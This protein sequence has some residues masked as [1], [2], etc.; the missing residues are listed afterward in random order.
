MQEM[1]AKASWDVA[2]FRMD[3]ASKKLTSMPF[4]SDCPQLSQ[5]P[6]LTPNDL[7]RAGDEGQGFLGRCQLLQ[8]SCKKPTSMSF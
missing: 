3:A 7:L 4:M 2:G 5:P 8:G 6:H 1:K